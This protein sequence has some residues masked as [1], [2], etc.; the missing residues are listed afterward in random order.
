MPST[1]VATKSEQKQSAGIIPADF[2]I[3]RPPVGAYGCQGRFIFGSS[4]LL[5][6]PTASNSGCAE[7][8][9]QEIKLCPAIGLPFQQFQSI[10]MPF[11]WPI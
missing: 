4:G 1:I 3:H 5:V 6:I 8:D 9:S 2:A 11:H 7:S 10:D